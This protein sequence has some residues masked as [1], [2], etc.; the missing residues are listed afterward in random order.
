MTQSRLTAL[1]RNS[2][3]LAVLL[4]LTVTPSDAQQEHEHR[5]SYADQEDSGIA[6]LDADELRGLLEGEGMGLART[7]ELNGY[8]GPK[9]VLELAEPLELTEEQHAAVEEVRLRMLESAR[10]L[11]EQVVEAE[12]LLDR[13]FQHGHI[14]A[15][16]VAELTEQIGVLTGRLRAVHLIAHLETR[17]LLSEEQTGR[18]D[19]LRGYDDEEGGEHGHEH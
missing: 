18:Y 2:L 9:H 7:A 4:L 10:S 6:A 17:A 13:R 15:D 14:D 1:L 16:T 8:P 19:E 5:S 12:R 3:L 11:G